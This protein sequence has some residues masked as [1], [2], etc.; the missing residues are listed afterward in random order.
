MTEARD[1]YALGIPVPEALLD[2]PESVQDLWKTIGRETRSIMDTT[3]MLQKP[4]PFWSYQVL[5]V[6]VAMEAH[7][8]NR[9]FNNAVQQSLENALGGVITQIEGIDDNWMDHHR[10]LA[11][12]LYQQSLHPRNT[13]PTH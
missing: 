13:H 8:N 9:G 3:E 6:F 5:K 1:P 10:R 7:R 4:V 11:R 2:Q 12:T